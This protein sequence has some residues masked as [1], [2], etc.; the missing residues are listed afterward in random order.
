M[1]NFVVGSLLLFLFHFLFLGVATI[2]T[3]QTRA[4]RIEPARSPTPPG[5]AQP[6]SQNTPTSREASAPSAAGTR[7]EVAEGDVVRVNTTLV[8]VP[9]SVTDRTGRY[10]A[11]LNKED[12]RIFE[13]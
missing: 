13:N 3:A 6:P 5:S 10:I 7:E 11:D 4:R 9:V 2:S 8:T 1:K 12:F